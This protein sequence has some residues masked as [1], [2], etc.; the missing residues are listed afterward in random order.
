MRRSDTSLPYWFHIAQ[1]ASFYPGKRGS[2]LQGC[3]RIEF[4]KPIVKRRFTLFSDV[5]N[6]IDHRILW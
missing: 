2:Y 4:A 3:H 1:V 6:E 5:D